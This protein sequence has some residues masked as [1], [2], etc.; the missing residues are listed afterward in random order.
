MGLISAS[1]ISDGKKEAVTHILNRS[2]SE[3][4]RCVPGSFMYI[5]FR[6]SWPK[7]LLFCNL[8]IYLDN[9]V[10]VMTWKKNLFVTETLS[11]IKYILSWLWCLVT[12][13]SKVRLSRPSGADSYAAMGA[14]CVLKTSA[15]CT[16]S[17]INTCPSRRMT[18]ELLELG[19]LSDKHGLTVL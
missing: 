10:G 8:F 19:V 5:D 17:V 9:T 18:L 16:G 13:L 15:T 3:L 1:F 2:Q 7:A 14:Q 4:H 6:P 11:R 12:A